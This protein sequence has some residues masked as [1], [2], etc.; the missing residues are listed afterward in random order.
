MDFRMVKTYER[1][2][3]AD[4]LRNPNTASGVELERDEL[5]HLHYQKVTAS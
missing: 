1:K 3:H 5:N 4:S 2:S